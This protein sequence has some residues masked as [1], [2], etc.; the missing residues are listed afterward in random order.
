M[1]AIFYSQYGSV[2]QLEL[3]EVPMP[4]PEADEVLI[5][6]QASAVNDYDWSAVTGKPA[7][8]RL[9][10]GLFKP[11]YPIPGMELSGIVEKVG[12]QV[13][14]FKVGD[15]VYGDISDYKFG[16]FAEYISVSE[17]ALTLKPEQMT[18][19]EAA[20]IPHAS[21]LA[22][23]GLID[24]GKIQH[25][26]KI[27]INGAGGGVGTFGLQLAKMYNAEVTGVDSA[28]KL[29][30]MKALG[31]DHVI[32]YR[33]TDFTKN[34]IQYDL[35]L[36]AKTT[37]S[38]FA[39]A[40]ALKPNGR[41]ITVGGKITRLL[42]MLWWSLWFSLFSSKRM[43]IL[44]LK[45][46]KGLDRINELFEAGKLKPMI[47]G[48]YPLQEAPEAIQYFGEG[49]HYGKVIISNQNSD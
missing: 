27:L 38:A 42:S 11:K 5:K 44:A 33:K 24:L 15:V 41:Y 21:L 30:K 9:L 23:Q 17:K 39:Y 47:D 48:P 4:T 19:E 36:D 35:I 22:Y 8:Y 1:K 25:A 7:I 13:T 10:F 12:D 6:I 46:N 3:K 14:A 31:F 49:K 2:D 26:E 16:A 28:A 32:D 29:E 34:K 37:R 43:Q 45:P 40:R 20:A 18:F